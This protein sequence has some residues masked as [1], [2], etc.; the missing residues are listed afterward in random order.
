MAGVVAQFGKIDILVNNAAITGA[1]KLAHDVTVE[2]WDAV[3]AVNVRGVFLC[4]KH[5]VRAMMTA[6]RGQHRQLFV[7]LRI[8]RQ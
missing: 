3:F 1:N 5:A 7:N 8:D 4:T 2:E 6:G